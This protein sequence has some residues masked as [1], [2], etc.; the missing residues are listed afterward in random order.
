MYTEKWC[1]SADVV[2]TDTGLVGLGESGGDGERQEVIDSY[3]GTSPWQ[4]LGDN[5]SLGLGTAMYDLMGQDAGVPCWQLFGQQVRRWTP[6]GSW[7]VSSD[8]AHMAEAVQRYA[9]AGFT[10]MKYHLSP[11]FNVFDQMDAI[12]A[13]APKD[14]QIHLDFT[15][16]PLEN[17]VG[18]CDQLAERYPCVGCF[19]D[20]FEQ[21]SLDKY[22]EFKLR[23]KKPVV[24]HHAP[25]GFTTEVSMGVADI[26][27]MGHS[28]IGK[29]VQASGHFAACHAPFM[30]QNVGGA[31]TLSMVSH[32]MSAFP[33]A[34]FKCHTDC[35]VYKYDVV[36]EVRTTTTS[37]LV[38]GHAY[39]NVDAGWQP[40]SR[41]PRARRHRQQAGRQA[42]VQGS[43][44]THH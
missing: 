34:T 23:A 14:F 32:M 19:E 1:C 26:Y 40:E 17:H 2:H 20:S 25:M 21:V 44:T 16:T 10:W 30:L 33:T 13:V 8:P 42:G 41:P 36:H 29:A 7:T 22:K 27:M 39:V 35:E 15:F 4:H 37:V 5:T 24:L 3:I 18:M 6:V 31:I 12:Q 28:P 11:F 38:R 9:A 43:Q